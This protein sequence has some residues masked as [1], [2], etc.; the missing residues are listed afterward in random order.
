MLSGAV[1]FERNFLTL[2]PISRLVSYRKLSANKCDILHKFLM[3]ILAGKASPTKYSAG[4]T[5]NL[6]VLGEYEIKLNG[7]SCTYY[8]PYKTKITTKQSLKELAKV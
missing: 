4:V 7:L 1:V 8:F 6:Q 2:L 5:S 3:E